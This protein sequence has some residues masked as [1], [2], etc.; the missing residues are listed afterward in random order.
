MSKMCH[1][2]TAETPCKSD[3]ALFVFF[4]HLEVNEWLLAN[5]VFPPFGC[6]AYQVAVSFCVLSKQGDVVVVRALAADLHGRRVCVVVDNVGFG[7]DDW[8]DAVLL[9]GRCQLPR[10][11]Q[12]PVIGD[13]YGT[14]VVLGHNLAHRAELL[15]AVSDR[16]IGV[17]MEMDKLLHYLYISALSDRKLIELVKQ[18]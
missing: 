1:D 14:L 7:S 8:L 13:C 11:A 16:V 5:R 15:D 18:G 9:G 2:W 4:E 6:H 3:H 17:V 10:A 12:R